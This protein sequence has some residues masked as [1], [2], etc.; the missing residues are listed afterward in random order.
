MARV[1]WRSAASKKSGRGHASRPNLGGGL[2]EYF[3]IEK[4]TLGLHAAG[5]WDRRLG[6]WETKN[7]P[8]TA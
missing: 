3:A 4:S 7:S 5:E 2:A 8:A 1:L 6:D